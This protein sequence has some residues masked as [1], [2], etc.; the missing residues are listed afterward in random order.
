MNN[1]LKKGKNT[2]LASYDPDSFRD[3]IQ[4]NK[5]IN[6]LP[7]LVSMQK[8]IQDFLKDGDYVKLGGFGQVRASMSAIYEIIKQGKK[9]LTI[10]GH[11]TSHDLDVLLAADAVSQVEVA[12]SFGHEFRPMRSPVGLRLIKEGKLKVTEWSNASFAWRLKGASMGLSF[13][14]ARFMLGTDTFNFSGAREIICPFTMQKYAALPALYPDVAI[15][16]VNRADIYGNCQ[17]DGMIVSDDDAA[18]ASRRV[19]ISAE[20]IVDEEVFLKDPDRTVI[21]YYNVDAVVLAPFGSYPCEMPGQYWFDEYEIANYLKATSSDAELKNYI[22]KYYHETQ[23]W[24]DYLQKIA[25]NKRLQDLVKIAKKEI[26][27]PLIKDVWEK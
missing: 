21:S 5:S 17:I 6:K 18:R 13:V 27:P 23:N 14:P 1:D 3:W 16:H 15:I 26:N 7:K 24:D 25:G 11:T 8:A 10:A 20:K 12:Y 4:N 2:P 9:N 19:I 22:K